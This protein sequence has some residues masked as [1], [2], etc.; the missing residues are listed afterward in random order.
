MTNFSKGVY[1]SQSGPKIAEWILLD[2]ICFPLLS[3]CLGHSA[4]F[5]ERKINRKKVLVLSFLDA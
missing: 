3:D 5:V 1:F 2:Y 4:V